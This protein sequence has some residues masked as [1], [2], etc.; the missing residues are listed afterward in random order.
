[1]GQMKGS[2]APNTLLVALA[3]TAVVASAAGAAS[4]HPAGLPLTLTLPSGWSAGGSS[5]TAV[6]NAGGGAGHLAVTKGGSFPSGVPYSEFVKTET[7]SATKAYK[8]ED[9]HA[10]VNGKK[11]ALPS[12]PAVQIRAT[13]QHGGAPVS[14]TLYS[15]LHNGVTYHFTFFTNGAAT[16]GDRAAFASIAKSIKY[17]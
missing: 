12:G 10:V 4:I 6:F 3:A 13:V 5:K 17:S 8:A 1:M 7:S 2:R 9:G 11:V 16:A 15:L 14:V